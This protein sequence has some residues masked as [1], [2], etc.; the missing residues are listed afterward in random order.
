MIARCLVKTVSYRTMNSVYGFAVA[1]AI[2]GKVAI[3]AAVAGAEVAYKMF[4]YFGHEW[5]WEKF[6]PRKP[7]GGAA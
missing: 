4:A 6:A 2:S 3:A 1:Y 7:A 5:V